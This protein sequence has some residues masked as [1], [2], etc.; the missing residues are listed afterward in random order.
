MMMSPMPASM[1]W[2]TASGKNPVSLPAL[3]KHSST[4]IAPATTPTASAASKPSSVTAPRTMT[5]IPAAGPLI[6]T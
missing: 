3:A 1:P 4:W 6:V 5:I 2:M